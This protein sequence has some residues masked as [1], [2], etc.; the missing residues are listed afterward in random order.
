[1]KYDVKIFYNLFTV[2]YRV[3][4]MNEYSARLRGLELVRKTIPEIPNR[5]ASKLYNSEVFY[6]GPLPRS[7]CAASQHLIE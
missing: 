7:Q 6:D 2:E 5:V 1:M 4:A 3:Y